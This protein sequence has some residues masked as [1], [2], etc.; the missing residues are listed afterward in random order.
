MRQYQDLNHSKQIWSN[1]CGQ[2]CQAERKTV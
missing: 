2:A 1:R